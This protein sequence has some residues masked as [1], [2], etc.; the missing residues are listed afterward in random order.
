MTRPHALL[1]CGGRS[2]EHP[3]SISSAASLM[4]AT[5]AVIE[6]SPRVIDQSGGWFD[7]Q[8]SRAILSGTKA[9][10]IDGRRGDIDL[11]A[12]R[13]IGLVFPLLHG[14]YG[15]DGRLQG[16]L[17]TL[18]IAY[19]GSGVL[20]SAVG[21]DKLAMKA[22]LAAAGLPQVAHRAVTRR[23][24]QHHRAECEGELDSLGFPCFVKPANLGSSIGIDRA[25][26]PEQRQAAIEVALRLDPRVIVEA[27]VNGA[28]EL[29]VA[30]LGGDEPR[31]SI[32][33][34]VRALGRFYDYEAKYTP[35]GAELSIPAKIP[36]EVAQ[37]ATAMALHT[38]Q[39]IDARGLAR[40]DLFWDAA[41]DQ[42][43][44]NEINTM[45]GFTETSMYPQLWAASGLSY[46]ELTLELLTLAQTGR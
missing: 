37:R 19:V 21:M 11:A 6:W 30:L 15:E 5:E 44:L 7:D 28:R 24:W 10:D 8:A 13:Q 45:P 46:P 41:A 32:V 26:T 20:A 12:L 23:A 34:E 14:P 18:G 17:D 27:A 29:E 35:G 38:F 25:D 4:R 22:M 42:L 2:A 33:G 9:T 3:V 1:L 36:P 16:L 39:S 31:A 40:V 43:Y